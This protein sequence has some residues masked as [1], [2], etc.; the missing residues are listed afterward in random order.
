[1][2]MGRQPRSSII[3]DARSGARLD[4]EMG[5]ASL[6]PSRVSP[7]LQSA[8]TPPA[9]LTVADLALDYVNP[10]TGD[11]HRAVEHLD[12]EVAANEFLCVLGPSGCGKS[13]LLAAI[14]G[15]LP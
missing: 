4:C 15:F 14:A 10:E 12:L 3:C 8:I 7:P 1:M 9:R 5:A 6:D 11:G 2:R 13:T